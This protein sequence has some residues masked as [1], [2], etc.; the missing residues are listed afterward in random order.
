MKETVNLR[1][2]DSVAANRLTK[3]GGRGNSLSPPLPQI[4]AER[5]SD[6][7]ERYLRQGLFP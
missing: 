4:V 3:G 7:E 1:L 2:G 5:R 6:C